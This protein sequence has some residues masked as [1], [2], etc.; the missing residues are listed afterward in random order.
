M[1]CI[2]VSPQ[3]DYATLDAQPAKPDWA[4]LDRLGQGMRMAM[5]L[6]LFGFDVIIDSETNQ[7]Y[8][9]DI[10]FFPGHLHTYHLSNSFYFYWLNFLLKKRIKSDLNTKRVPNFLRNGLWFFM[11]NKL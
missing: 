10:N 2:C 3:V 4:F 6:D 8:I 1:N 7:Y 11:S 9:I 5:E